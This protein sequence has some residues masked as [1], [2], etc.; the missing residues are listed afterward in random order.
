MYLHNF[1]NLLTA[2]PVLWWSHSYHVCIAWFLPVTWPQIVFL[3]IVTVTA[4]D[5]CIIS[6][7]D[8]RFVL[9]CCWPMKNSVKKFVY[10]FGTYPFPPLYGDVSSLMRLSP[11]RNV[12][13]WTPRVHLFPLP[14]HNGPTPSPFGHNKILQR[15][16]SVNPVCIILF[17]TMLCLS[18]LSCTNVIDP[19]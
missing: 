1:A 14:C 4:L 6:L 11:L 8:D 2:A 7:D 13:L 12:A 5:M 17:V 3:A 18:W 16:V 15:Y 19:L 9:P 10:N